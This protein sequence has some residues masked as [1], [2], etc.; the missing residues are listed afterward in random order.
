MKS[1]KKLFEFLAMHTGDETF[2]TEKLEHKR[3]SN[4]TYGKKSCIYLAHSS[5]DNKS[6]LE[7]ALR[8]DGFNVSS[9]YAM[10]KSSEIQVSYF[11]G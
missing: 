4:E 3:I 1:K 9:S 6:E 11:K 10:P 2:K 5:P 7:T 8:A